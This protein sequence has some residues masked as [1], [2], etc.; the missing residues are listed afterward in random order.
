M[1]KLN[2]QEAMQ[3]LK[4]IEKTENIIKKKENQRKKQKEEKNVDPNRPKKQASSFLLFSKEERKK[5]V[6]EKPGTNNTTVNALISLK[7]KSVFVALLMLL[8]CVRICSSFDATQLFFNHSCKE[9]REL[10]NRLVFL[11]LQLKC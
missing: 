3:L 11:F 10:T 4:K 6:E 5:I 2:K 7:W 9:F 8:S 1:I